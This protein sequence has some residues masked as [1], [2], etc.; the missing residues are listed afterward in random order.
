MWRD[1]FIHGMAHSYVTWLIH[2]WHGSFIHDMAHSYVTWFFHMWHGSFIHDMAHSYVTWLVHMWQ[3]SR[4]EVLRCA[5]AHQTECGIIVCDLLCAMSHRCHKTYVVPWTAHSV[6]ASQI[7]WYNVCHGMTECVVQGTTYEQNAWFKAQRM[8]CTEYDTTYVMAW[9]NVW[10]KA[11]RMNRM[12]GSRHNVCFV[13][14]A[15]FHVTYEWVMSHINAS[16]R[17]NVCFVRD[18]TFHVT[19]CTLTQ[20]VCVYVGWQN[21]CVYTYVGKMWHARHTYVLW[22]NAASH[23]TFCTVTQCVCMYVYE[24]TLCVWMYVDRMW[25]SR[26]GCGV[27]LVSRID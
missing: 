14:D 27:A 3:D 21:M 13:R 4:I 26:H 17:H 6:M 10:F 5:R 7:V 11:Q 12:C 23:A 18:A 22:C 24:H 19:F 1:S 8:C 20:C 16:S 2:M 15:T 9:Q 25:Q